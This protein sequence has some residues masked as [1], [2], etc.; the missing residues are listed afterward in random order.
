M[1]NLGNGDK[2][3]LEKNM[4]EIKDLVSNDNEQEQQQQASNNQNQG[5]GLGQ[6][7][8]NQVQN[9]QTLSQQ[10]NNTGSQDNLNQA[11]QENNAQNTQEVQDN[12]QPENVE[13]SSEGFEQPE[14]VQSSEAGQESP[15][16]SFETDSQRH[17]GSEQVQNQGGGLD[18]SLRQLKDEIQHQMQ[19]KEQELDTLEHAEKVESED[20]SETDVN[21]SEAT[22][23]LSR[24]SA[25][26]NSL[27]LEVNKFEK[28]KS[29]VEEMRNLSHEM[30]TVM[31]DLDERS[32][33]AGGTEQEAQSLLNEFAERRDE[34]ERAVSD[35]S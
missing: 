23:Q 31:D 29:L 7:Q 17:Q 18:E 22:Q 33:Q 9:N 25:E 4:E 14:S 8:Q 21:E 15:E 27:F 30:G 10:N 6:S 28:V 3:K 16:E 19:E 5:G 26:G 24:M 2:E 12:S 32:D 20:Y 35:K 1:F 13:S 34:L 11:F